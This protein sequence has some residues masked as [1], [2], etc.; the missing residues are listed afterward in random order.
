MALPIITADQRLAE[1]RCVKGT[2]F[3]KSGI[4]KT[5]LLRTL[6]PATTLFIDL[7]AGDLAIEGWSGDSVRPRTWAECRDFAVFIGGPYPALRDDQGYSDARYAG[8][9][10]RPAIG[11]PYQLRKGTPPRRGWPAR[12]GVVFGLRRG[13]GSA[14]GGLGPGS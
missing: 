1:Q 12:G 6:D 9:V 11:P 4:G 8:R 14:G 7:E 10:N 2:I 3:G 5:S 13:R